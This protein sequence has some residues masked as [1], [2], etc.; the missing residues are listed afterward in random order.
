MAVTITREIEFE[1]LVPVID[2]CRIE[3]MMLYGTATLA[4][5]DQE[6]EPR[7]FYVREVDLSGFHIDR[8][9][10]MRF[11]VTFRDKLFVAIASQIESMATHIGRY[12]QAEF[13]EAVE[14]A[15]EPDPDQAHQQ[16]IDDQFYEAAE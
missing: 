16:R 13:S 3:G 5:N 9:R 1:E 15:S 8:P 12:A 10:D 6:N 7:D 14:S 2:E 4:S 11:P